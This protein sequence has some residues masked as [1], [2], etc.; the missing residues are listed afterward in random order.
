MRIAQKG[1]GGIIHNMYYFDGVSTP[2]GRLHIVVSDAALHRIYFPG[3]S[4]TEHY[5]RDAKHPLITLTKTQLAEYFSGQRRIFDIPLDP[6]GSEFQKKV[7][8][9]LR[10]IPYGTTLNYAEEAKRAGKAAAARAVGS[11]NGKNPIPIII[12]CHRVVPKSGGLGGYSGGEHRKA[13]L[14][15]LERHYLVPEMMPIRKAK[16]AKKAKKATKQ[17]KTQAKKSAKKTNTKA[18]KTGS[19]KSSEKN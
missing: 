18:K 15:K 11:A 6:E 14:I 2:I 8:N 5:E 7:W 10:K 16:K 17:Q 3:E 12:P 1:E 19:K 13:L 9:V 4:W